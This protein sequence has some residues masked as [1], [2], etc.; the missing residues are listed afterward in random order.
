MLQLRA[1]LALPVRSG[2]RVN[3]GKYVT[4]RRRNF[5]GTKPPSKA[6]FCRKREG[7]CL[8]SPAL[9]LSGVGTLAPRLRSAVPAFCR[10]GATVAVGRVDAGALA[11]SVLGG[12][13]KGVATFAK[14]KQQNSA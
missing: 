5:G 4:K 9:P 14:L 8:S 6:M 11:A 10:H 1:T 2:C 3:V 12:S 7:L 13:T